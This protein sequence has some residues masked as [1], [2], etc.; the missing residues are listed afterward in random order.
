MVTRWAQGAQGGRAW[1]W[2]MEPHSSSSLIFHH[3]KVYFS[4]GSWT[5]NLHL[6]PIPLANNPMIHV[7][8]P[9]LGSYQGAWIWCGGEG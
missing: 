7:F 4:L 9:C 2:R 8:L 3:Q 1:E 6:D 5:P